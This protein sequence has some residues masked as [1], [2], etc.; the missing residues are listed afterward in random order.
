MKFVYI[1]LSMLV[2]FFAIDMVWLGA[3]AKKFYANQLGDRMAENPN[4]AVAALFYASYI[5]G[6]FI[7]AVRP[8]A[9]N[10]S[11]LTGLI[12]GGL[13]GF[14]CYATYD[15]T[16]LATLKNWPVTMVWVDILW[17]VAITGVTAAIGSYVAL[18]LGLK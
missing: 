5:V 16:N 7:F 9:D 14:F 1:Y 2:T 11:V 6:I 15:F 8:A 12:M 13:F 10:G 18:K 3:V 17:G 4:W